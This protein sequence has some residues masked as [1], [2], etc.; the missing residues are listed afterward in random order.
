[1]GLNSSLVSELSDSI[2]LRISAWAEEL[3]RQG[4]DVIS[5][6]AGEPDFLT[7]DF[8]KEAAKDAID[9]NFT[10]YTPA[11]GAL[12]LREAVADYIGKST[13]VRY[14]YEQVLVS[15]GAKQ[16]IF[17]VLVATLTPGEKVIVPRPY[18]V[19]YP[20]M[21]RIAGGKT[22]FWDINFFSSNDDR[23]NLDQLEHLLDNGASVLLLN[24]P[25][26]PAGYVLTDREI[27]SLARL[28]ERR[29]ITVIS[30]EIYD[31]I[32]FD[33]RHHISI[34]RYLPDRTVVV[35]GVSKSFSMTGWRIGFAAGPVDIISLA[36]KV[37]AHTTSSPCSIS[38]KA[39]LAAITG[40]SETV[41]AVRAAFEHRRDIAVSALSQ[42]EGIALA[43]PE[44]TF[45]LLPDVSS[46][47][48][49]SVD[50]EK[51]VTSFDLCKYLL[52]KVF[53]ACVPADAFGLPGFIRLSFATGETEII[54]GI[55]RMRSALLRLG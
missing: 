25:N 8:V 49:R 9:D 54:S 17:N 46:F 51:V 55:D 23:L 1:M 50:G 30:D 33:G 40:P 11:A 12:T 19:S 48:N 18:W 36:A 47:L 32:I 42:I 43:V 28:L 24:S 13:G 10:R 3:K 39:A 53:V 27:L 4:I 20:E 45:Y 38:Q 5:F 22:V 15:S 31:K 2:T 14:S 44:G 6:S 37:Q 41:D 52:N 34:A 26:N 7:P 21:V 16:A 29:D 35:N